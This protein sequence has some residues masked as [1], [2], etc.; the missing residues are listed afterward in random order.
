MLWKVCAQER[1]VGPFVSKKSSLTMKEGLSEVVRPDLLDNCVQR[2][3]SK[4]FKSLALDLCPEGKRANQ[5]RSSGRRLFLVSHP[6][7]IQ[8][9]RGTE[10]SFI[11]FL[12]LDDF[13]LK[14]PTLAERTATKPLRVKRQI[15]L[16]VIPCVSACF[17]LFPSVSICF[18][19][20]LP[21]NYA[22]H[23]RD[24]CPSRSGNPDALLFF[25]HSRV[26]ET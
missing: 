25:L 8:A 9:E 11:L 24:P 13:S 12:F 6:T 16:R 2:S 4:Y 7:Q 14:R 20:T 26:L 23:H 10:Q 1:Y 17:R 5:R 18:R 15:E 22:V 19:L 3:D 21:G